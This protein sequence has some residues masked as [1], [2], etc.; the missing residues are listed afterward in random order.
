MIYFDNAASSYP[1]PPSVSRAVAAWLRENGANPGRSGHAPAMRAAEEI[2]KTREAICRLFGVSDADRIAFVPNTTYGLNQII[3]GVLGQ[4]GHAVT[5]D[6]EH[7][8]VLRPLSYL[9]TRGVSFSI[10]NVDLYD[11]EATIENILALIRDDTKLI[12]CTQCSNVCGKVMPVKAL[13]RALGGRIPLLVDGAQG[14]GIIPTDLSDL[15]V[16]YYCAPSHKGLLGPQGSGFVA[17]LGD[18]PAPFITGGTGSESFDPR[19]P[20]YL[21]DLLESGTLSTP[22][23]VG[24]RM[25]VEFVS[26]VGV[27]KIYEKKKRLL[28]I[29]NEALRDI[30]GA[31]TYIDHDRSL[32]CG[33]VPFNIEGS[34]S[35]DVASFLAK[36]G[37]CVRSG[38]HCAPLFH[39]K[40]GTEAV[41]MVRASFS[42]YN[43]VREIER[44]LNI[45]KKYSKN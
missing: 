42:Y 43:S 12:V 24:M 10:A 26:S 32:F 8:S 36:Y 34:H 21:P 9:K 35:D 25:G 7:N 22:C 2:Y 6:L 16:D 4:G 19:Q 18:P 27:E 30:P 23:I 44:F 41:G 38:I 14:A 11:D 5:T 28:R 3:C 15:G 39:R 40:M 37:I 33:T 1:K 45:L 20:E 31:V 17:V 29:T 13:S